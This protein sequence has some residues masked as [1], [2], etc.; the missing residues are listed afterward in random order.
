[1]L[2]ESQPLPRVRAGPFELDSGHPQFRGRS[3]NGRFMFTLMTSLLPLLNLLLEIMQAP[4]HVPSTALFLRVE[5][6]LVT[7][8]GSIRM[9][10]EQKET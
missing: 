2:L 10:D 3:I 6:D 4:G 7:A 9:A 1:M 5:A 8:H